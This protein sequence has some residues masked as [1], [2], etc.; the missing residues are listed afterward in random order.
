MQV[1]NLILE[2]EV[3]HNGF[4]LLVKM[5]KQEMPV[6]IHYLHTVCKEH[7]RQRNMS[8]VDVL[9]CKCHCTDNDFYM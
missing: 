4:H 9:H 2:L 7:L 5:L 6:R 1:S 8:C 3:K